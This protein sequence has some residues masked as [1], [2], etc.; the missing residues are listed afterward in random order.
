MDLDTHGSERFFRAM[1]RLSNSAMLITDARVP[2]NPIV[3]V[4]PAFERLVGYRADEVIGRNCR[5]L[6][7]DDTQQPGRAVLADAIRT[8]KPC[9]ALLRNYRKNGEMFWTCIY[10]FPVT[11]VQGD[12]TH[13]VGIQHDVTADTERIKALR[14]KQSFI[15]AS[16]EVYF[17]IATDLTIVQVHGACQAISGWSAADLLGKNATAFIP[18]ERLADAGEKFQTL[19]C[20]DAMSSFSAEYSTREGGQVTIEWN[21]SRT[22]SGDGILLVGRDVTAKRAAERD[23]SRAHDRIASVLG[24]ITEGCFSL[25]RNWVCTY[26]ND[27]AGEWLSRHPSD[28]VGKNLW[29]EFPQAVGSVFYQTYHQAMDTKRFGQCEAFYP[30]LDKWLEARAYPSEDGLTIFFLDI[31]E[32]K[33]HEL[34]LI[35][36]ATHDALTNLPNRN[37]CLEMLTTCLGAESILGKGVAVIF[38]DLDHFKEIN[39]AFGHVIGDNVLRKIG[40]RLLSFRSAT[41]YPSRM[42]G[43]EFIVIVSDD[44]E[45]RVTDLSI[46][47]MSSI[48]E[49]ISVG[50]RG[51]ITIGASVGIALTRGLTT[52]ADDLINQADT[53]MY[54]SKANGRHA[55]TVYSGDVNSWHLKRHRLRQDMLQALRNGEFCLHYQPQV[56]LAGNQLVGA[57]ALIRWQHPEF[58]LLSP[59]AF[60]DIA[61]ES[62]LIIELGAWVFDEA[63]RQLRLWQDLGHSLKMSVN[64]SARQL[65][66]RD[67]PEMMVQSIGRHG[68]SAHCMKLEITESML[69]QDFNAA[70]DVLSGLKR[71]GFRIALDDFGTGYSN[72]A[73]LSRLPVTAIKIDRSFVTPLTMDKMALSIIKG[74][75]ALAK[76][77]DLTVICEGV[78]TAEQRSLLESTQC[79]SI[80]GYLVSPPLPAHEFS[81]RFLEQHGARASE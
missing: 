59:A 43:D 67:M 55:L 2:D 72:L 39:D 66:N 68:V 47:I 19:L 74:I 14:E 76:S 20:S 58:G 1:L 52:T 48:A 61:E 78:E 64:V 36:S 46:Q 62:P 3:F 32:R 17:K 75:V 12:I 29:A 44:D 22:D 80:Q 45:A 53:A 79:D 18:R 6:Q 7:N 34:A 11:D 8:G 63:C 54:A 50:K 21:A 28:L 4:N 16:A 15:D 31:S 24:S 49:P 57:E 51:D 5:L 23:V 81:M 26:M 30:P 35:Y 65:A 38:I 25:D 56:S 42:S 77:L 69:A 33:R 27:K 40:E 37:A 60:L 41:C 10:I 13:F 9:E 71:R 73:Y 70:S